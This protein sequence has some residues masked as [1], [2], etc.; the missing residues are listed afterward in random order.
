LLAPGDTLHGAQETRA[1]GSY[2]IDP[3]GVPDRDG[4][5]AA[6]AIGRERA[7]E[8]ARLPLA[9]FPSRLAPKAHA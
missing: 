9:S 3:T 1:P 5:I 8:L 7:E 4:L 2:H 6:P